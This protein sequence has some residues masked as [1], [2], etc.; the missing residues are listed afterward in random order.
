MQKS[1]RSAAGRAMTRSAP[2]A[3]W[4][5][6]AFA[7]PPSC[8]FVSF[9]PSREVVRL[10]KSARHRIVSSALHDVSGEQGTSDM[11]G[12]RRMLGE[13]VLVDWWMRRWVTDI[14]LQS[15]TVPSNR[16]Q[17]T[18]STLYGYVQMAE[19]VFVRTPPWALRLVWNLYSVQIIRVEI[20]ML[21]N[22]RAVGS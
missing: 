18:V 17:T 19:R 8:P 22:C 9:C 13:H 5:I 20:S 12:R 21:C 4:E 16:L 11:P 15:S 1:G 6:L 2:K 10:G 3:I 7:F 14:V